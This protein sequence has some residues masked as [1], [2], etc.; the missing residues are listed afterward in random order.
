M[1]AE[2]DRFLRSKGEGVR[3]GNLRCELSRGVGGER[4]AAPMLVCAT[5]TYWRFAP[6]FG[7]FRQ[8]LPR[9]RPPQETEAAQ[10]VLLGSFG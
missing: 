1:G 2:R 9:A 3:R 10:R 8:F 7:R 4:L 6:K 5:G